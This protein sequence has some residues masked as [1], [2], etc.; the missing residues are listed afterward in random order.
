MFVH[1]L[2]ISYICKQGWITLFRAPPEGVL[3]QLF[4]FLHVFA[5]HINNTHHYAISKIVLFAEKTMSVPNRL[6]VLILDDKLVRSLIGKKRK[7]RLT[8]L[9]YS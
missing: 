8:E 9:A 5:Y 2:T 6:N 1:C 3:T 7:F 4:N